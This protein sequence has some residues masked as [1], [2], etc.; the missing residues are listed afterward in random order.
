[1]SQQNAESPLENN[2]NK[3]QMSHPHITPAAVL[4]NYNLTLQWGNKFY[5]KG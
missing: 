5:L 2:N 4:P 3:N 1:M